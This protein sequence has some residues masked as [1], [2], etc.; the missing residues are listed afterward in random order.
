M[1]HERILIVDDDK[2]ILRLLRGYL[3]Q[4]GYT[5]YTARTAPLPST[6]CAEQP[7]S[8]AAGPDAARPRRLGDHA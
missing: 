2:E 4:A 1:P 8:A 3:E 6:P 7:G 5:V